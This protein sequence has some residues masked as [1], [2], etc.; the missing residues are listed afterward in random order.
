MNIKFRD[1]G[2]E[3]LVPQI[4]GDFFCCLGA[5]APAKNRVELFV[6]EIAELRG[7]KFEFF[8]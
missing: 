3:H 2:I 5:V 8:G 4:L 1:D 7:G 6:G